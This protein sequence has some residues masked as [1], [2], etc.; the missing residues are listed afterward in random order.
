KVNGYIQEEALANE[1]TARFYLE[2]DKEG[3]AQIYLAN[4][5]YNYVNWGAIAKVNQLSDQYPQFLAIIQHPQ[6]IGFSTLTR[7][8]T[9]GL[10]YT[11]SS[12]F[13][14]L[15]LATVMKASHALAGEIELEKLLTTLMQVVIENAGAEKSVLLLLQEDN[16][17]VAAEK[18]NN[19]TVETAMPTVVT[20]QCPSAVSYANAIPQSEEQTGE[21]LGII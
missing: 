4:A 11:T 12:A 5:Y 13:E 18:T 1:L 9:T 20:E 19:P 8:T 21:N 16:W 15:D 10:E 14:A 17:V 6:E 2:W 7:T 3:I